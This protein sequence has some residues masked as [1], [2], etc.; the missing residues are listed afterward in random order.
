MCARFLRRPNEIHIILFNFLSVRFG[1]KQVARKSSLTHSPS[2]LTQVSFSLLA[3]MLLAAQSTSFQ[4]P[5]LEPLFY[6]SKADRQ[7]I[8]QPTGNE[9]LSQLLS[10]GRPREFVAKRESAREIRDKHEATNDAGSDRWWA[11]GFLG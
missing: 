10:T 7:L 9:P 5:D 6:W 1:P 2:L 3:K 8:L 4:T 11:T